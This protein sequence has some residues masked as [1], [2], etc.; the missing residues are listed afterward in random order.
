MVWRHGLTTREAVGDLVPLIHPRLPS[1]PAEVDPSPV[2]GRREVQQSMLKASRGKTNA[3]GY[4]LLSDQVL[5]PFHA[6]VHRGS[7]PHEI[8]VIGVF[9][10]QNLRS[11]ER[12]QDL[13]L[14][15]V[16]LY[17]IPEASDLLHDSLY[18]GD[19][20]VRLLYGE[21]LAGKRLGHDQTRC[22]SWEGT[23]ERQG[24]ADPL[25]G[26]TLSKVTT[27]F[28]DRHTR[29]SGAPPSCPWSK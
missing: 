12:V 26:T 9:G 25:T 14:S 24:A 27:I 7:V 18:G 10:G 4:D 2:Q 15:V 21:G 1:T 6:P 3:S 8:R 11:P 16:A 13:K 29:G 23:S 20:P 5:D 28:F 22:V 19:E 17:Q